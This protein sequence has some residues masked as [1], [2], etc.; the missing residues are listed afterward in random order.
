M[1]SQVIV[2]ARR[3]NLPP[4]IETNAADFGKVIAVVQE[5]FTQLCAKLKKLVCHVTMSHLDDI[6]TCVVARCQSQAQQNR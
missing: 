4:G 2:K 1:W 6:L 5:A 3:F